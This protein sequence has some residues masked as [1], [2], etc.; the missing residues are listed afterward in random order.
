MNQTLE[1]TASRATAWANNLKL[2]QAAV[3]L[4]TFLII[5]LPWCLGK[6]WWGVKWVMG[7]IIV[8]FKLGA[9]IKDKPQ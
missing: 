3:N 8:G 6:L 7:V 4:L 2:K 9:H 1:Q 5:A